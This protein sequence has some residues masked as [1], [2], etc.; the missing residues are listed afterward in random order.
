MHRSRF[1]S[2]LYCLGLAFFAC[3]HSPAA[4]PIDQPILLV[5]GAPSHGLV[6][7]EVDL[8][9]AMRLCHGELPPN[10]GLEAVDTATGTPVPI[11]FIP[12]ANRGLSADGKTMSDGI[13]APRLHGR[14]VLRLP[15][16]GSA[17]L[18][19]NLIESASTESAPFDGQVATAS[20]EVFHDTARQGGLPWKI[21]FPK[22]GK[23][24]DSLRWQ[25]RV[26]R[27]D[28]GSWLLRD[29]DQ[30]AVRR[31]ARGPL[32]TVVAVDATYQRSDGN[33]PESNPA[34]RY[35]WIY[36]HNLPLALVEWE[37][38]QRQ[39]F[40]WREV[41]FLEMNYPGEALPLY[42]GGDPPRSGELTGT[43]KSHG[44]DRWAAVHDGENS[45]GM[46]RA[47]RV[48][49]H[50][51][52]GGY[53]CYLHARGAAA[54]QQW[55]GL[56]QRR[57]AWL[58][59]ASDEDPAAAIP[60]AEALLPGAG[61]VVVTTGRLQQELEAARATLAAGTQN[62]RSWWAVAAAEQLQSEGHPKEA[63]KALSGSLPENWTIVEAG[64][65][66]AVFARQQDGIEPVSLFDRRSRR[67][68]LAARPAPL[69]EL[70]L[71]R[72]R[73][74]GT[75]SEE[76]GDGSPQ[77]DSAGPDSR[78][79]AAEEVV[80][81]A[82][83]GWKQVAIVKQRDSGDWQFTWTSPTFDG[84]ADFEVT[85]T[86]R[87]D[88]E[89]SAIIWR[90]SVDNP[91]QQWTVRRAVFPQ[92]SLG[93]GLGSDLHVL[94]PRGAG[95]VLRTRGAQLVEARGPY[96]GGWISMQYMAAYDA[97]G[98][99]GLYL[100]RH[101][102]FGSTKDL[103][104]VGSAEGGVQLYFDH[105]TPHMDTPGNDLELP[106]ESVWQLFRGDWFDAS[107][108]YRDWVRREAKWY[109]QLGP[110]GRDD[111]PQWMRELCFWT[112]DGG[113]AKHRVEPSKAMSE[114]LGMP[115]GLHWYSWHQIPFDNDYP[116]YFPTKEGF[117][118]AVAELQSAGVY[119]MPYINGRLW[120][121]HDRGV[122]D[123]EFSKVAQP[124]AT[125]DE[126]GQPYIERYSSKESDGNRVELAV[127]CPTTELWR[128]TLKQIVLRLMNECGVQA[129]YM[130][131][132]A[133]AKP[134]LCFDADHGHPAGGG[135]WWTEAYWELLDRIRQ[136][137]PE[138]RVLTSECNA[139]PFLR[140]F[141]GY[142]TWHWQYE[143]QVPAFP[144]VYGGAIQMFGRAYRGGDTKNLA[145]RMKAGQQLVY[146]E[147]IGW[148]NP[149]VLKEPEN[150][151]FL[152]KVART[153]AALV[154]YFYAGQMARPP[155]LNGQIPR[156][157]ADW[158]WSGQWWVE[159]DAVM[160]GAWQQPTEN[161][162][163]I[164]V[165]NVGDEAVKVELNLNLGEYGL[166]GNSFAAVPFIDGQKGEPFDHRPMLQ[167]RLELPPRC[168]M[169]WD[170]RPK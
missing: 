116:H 63:L 109:P 120:D 132:I 136:A 22:S 38:E 125:K 114:F 134:V 32:C 47:G 99:A 4:E 101:D 108:I 55:G 77:T 117:A 61:R 154:R 128:N 138:D 76:S 96:P 147:Q 73:S 107:V 30:S 129:V 113:D 12:A 48:L 157:R 34:A 54:W 5:D 158:Q 167:H 148:I 74:I 93:S 29:N 155:K 18:R 59:I 62:A 39:P 123:F 131:Q 104:A 100:A 89:R 16:G 84:L 36:F 88:P 105:P 110:E 124:A 80:L 119:V 91:G 79:D 26:Y 52:K 25:D 111:T 37:F 153:R 150:A 43:N 7:A 24:F 149:G 118:K 75:A 166:S 64:E 65:L 78:Q 27:K 23:V 53:G 67:N 17:R 168:V 95:Q 72:H 56:H 51:G 106:G 160:T 44:F 98:A 102:P 66:G 145:L 92:L 35:R 122:E 50:D 103:S 58:R 49:V 19:L 94:F 90:L 3:H 170:I 126:Q 10:V 135:H 31:V 140:W 151:D 87:V 21:V 81:R 112:L 1:R 20:Y 69:F 60:A 139:E 13:K 144:A 161:R 156:V 2:I 82:D 162:L 141:D 143:D 15:Q 28:V 146:G 41:H 137:M 70:T 46:L 40:P 121:T 83:E 85:A 57:T 165:V 71:R 11:Q 97:T 33:R 133:A 152:R 68:L 86:A 159:T 127:M 14:I 9:E 164:I 130:D 115:I 6:T 45:I 142:L 169:A 163:A 42:A 8:T